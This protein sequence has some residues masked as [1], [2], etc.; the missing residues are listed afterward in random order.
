[1]IQNSIVMKCDA[2]FKHVVSRTVYQSLMFKYFLYNGS[3]KYWLKRIIFI[4]NRQ[5]KIIF[6]EICDLYGH[7]FEI[8]FL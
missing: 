4:Q 6:Y 2:G 1:M 5:F 3:A 8:N 7:N